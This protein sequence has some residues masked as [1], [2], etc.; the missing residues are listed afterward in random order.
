MALNSVS[1]A[2]LR[3]TMATQ[4]TWTQQSAFKAARTYATAN[5]VRKS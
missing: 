3:R 1:R 4:S 2:A 5:K